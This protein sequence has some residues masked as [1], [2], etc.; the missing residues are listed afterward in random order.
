MKSSTAPRTGLA[1]LVTTLPRLWAVAPATAGKSIAHRRRP[2]AF[3]RWASAAPRAGRV[4]AAPCAG[5]LPLDVLLS[6]RIVVGRA[7]RNLRQQSKQRAR[8]SDRMGVAQRLTSMTMTVD[9]GGAFR[10][11]RDVM[12][13]AQVGVH[14]QLTV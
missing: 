6:A 5:S 4:G 10:A 12:R 13:R 7:V 14:S 11:E 1:K 9:F 3:R 2:A 8:D